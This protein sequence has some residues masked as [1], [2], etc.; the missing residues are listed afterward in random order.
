MCR[1]KKPACDLHTP[2]SAAL[3]VQTRTKVE[4]VA[5]FTGDAMLEMRAMTLSYGPKY[6]AKGRPLVEESENT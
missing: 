1:K 3:T 6:S 4:P 5:I 2:F